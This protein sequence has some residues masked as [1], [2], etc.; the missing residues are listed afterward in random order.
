MLAQLVFDNCQ[1]NYNHQHPLH[2]DN[3]SWMTV[4]FPEIRTRSF[5]TRN[6]SLFGRGRKSSILMVKAIVFYCTRR[7]LLRAVP[8]L[9]I[10][11]HKLS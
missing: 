9:F 11:P 4:D 2:Q 1:L 3:W 7:R 6:C 10:E 5:P 8:L